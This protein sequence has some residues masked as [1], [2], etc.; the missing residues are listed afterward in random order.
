MTQ[1][2]EDALLYDQLGYTDDYQ[3]DSGTSKVGSPERTDK[4]QTP[5]RNDSIPGVTPA[6][7]VTG[8][9]ASLVQGGAKVNQAKTQLEPGSIRLPEDGAL[10]KDFTLR[11]MRGLPREM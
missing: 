11:D 5:V 10:I 9:A 6:A 1:E 2:E 3:V 4:V 7:G 8:D